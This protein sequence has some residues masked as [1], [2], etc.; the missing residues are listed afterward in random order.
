MI[1]MKLRPDP[2]SP[3]SVWGS[4]SHLHL[5]SNSR[6]S[7]LLKMQILCSPGWEWVFHIS[8]KFPSWS[9]GHWSKHYTWGQRALQGPSMRVLCFLG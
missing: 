6:Q 4:F 1:A 8:R 5:S 2:K 9:S 3:V 7:V